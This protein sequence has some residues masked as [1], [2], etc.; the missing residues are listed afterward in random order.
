MTSPSLRA[1]PRNITLAML[2]LTLT[3]GAFAVPRIYKLGGSI[4]GTL[5]RNHVSIEAAQYMLRL[6]MRRSLPNCEGR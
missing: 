1:R 4:R 2:V 5:Y 6:S 3:I